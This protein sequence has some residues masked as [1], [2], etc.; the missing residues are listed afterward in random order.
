MSKVQLAD[1]AKTQSDVQNDQIWNNSISKNITKRNGESNITRKRGIHYKIHPH[2]AESPKVWDTEGNSKPFQSCHYKSCNNSPDSSSLITL[3]CTL[4][5]DFRI[6]VGTQRD[7]PVISI[8]LVNLYV[9][10]RFRS[11]ITRLASF[12]LLNLSG[13]SAIRFSGSLS[14]GNFPP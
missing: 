4:C 14:I 5:C 2:A 13:K 1:S 6:S 3:H 7:E 12:Q 11:E 10:T 8:Y 9:A